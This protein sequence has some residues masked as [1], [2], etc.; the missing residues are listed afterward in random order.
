MVTIDGGHGEGGGQIVRTALALAVALRRPVTLTAVRARRPRPGLQAQHLAAVRALATAS[1]AQVQGAGLHSTALE[2]RPH[3]A[4]G[5][6]YRVDVG[7]AGAVSLVF[8]AL[9]LP[10]AFADRPSRLTLV[11]GTHVPWS[12]PVHYLG[13]VL[14]P[15]LRRMGVRADV[16]LRQWGWYPRG[17]GVLEATVT[18]IGLETLGAFVRERR[19]ADVHVCGL[20]AVSHLPRSIAERQARRARERLVAGGITAEVAVEDA[21][22]ALGPGTFVFL[23]AGASAGF[24][25]LGA[26]GRPAERVADAAVDALLS[27]R[28]S[29]AAID[30]HLADQLLPFCALARQPSRFTCPALSPHLETVA[31]IVERFLPV[32]VRFDPGPPAVVEVARR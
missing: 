8:Q 3:A 12:P 26:P 25:A 7:T 28:T 24:S 17:G 1:D 10:L 19:E 14:L 15:S 16:G 22:P 30:T 21:A 32:R 18:P 27:W 4:R 5:G 20:S 11:G 13:D 2:F 6:T 23:A 31:W 29:G 9:L